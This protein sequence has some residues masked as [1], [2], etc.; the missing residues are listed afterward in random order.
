MI[1]D[2][3]NHIV[4]KKYQQA[5]EKKVSGRDMNLPSANWDKMIPT[6]ADLDAR[7]RVMDAFDD[8]I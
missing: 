7:F 5:I 4:P 6:L 1:I 8:Y 3:Y 2:V